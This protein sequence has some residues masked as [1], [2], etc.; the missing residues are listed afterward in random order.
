MT[1][2]T[3]ANG[4]GE[5]A[6][7]TLLLRVPSQGLRGPARTHR[8]LMDALSVAPLGSLGPWRITSSRA[9]P[10]RTVSA[11]LR[12]LVAHQMKTD[13]GCISHSD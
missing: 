4:I 8:W 9:S 1:L 3:P 7:E 11:R 13:T 12:G 2:Q 10:E 5:N 6:H